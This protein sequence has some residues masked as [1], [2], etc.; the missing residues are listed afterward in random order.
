MPDSGPAD[1]TEK[2]YSLIV[3]NWYTFHFI[4]TYRGAAG[5]KSVDMLGD[6]TV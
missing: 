2:L 5:N 1:C 6:K 4:Y 3:T